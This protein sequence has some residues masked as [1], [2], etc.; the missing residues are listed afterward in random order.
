M[1]VAEHVRHLKVVSRF[2]L[3]RSQAII[4]D[5]MFDILSWKNEMCIFSLLGQSKCC[6]IE[7]F[8]SVKVCQAFPARQYLH[9][10]GI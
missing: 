1:S 6:N 4:S 3:I 7:N 5:K 8:F 9:V 2:V 10:L